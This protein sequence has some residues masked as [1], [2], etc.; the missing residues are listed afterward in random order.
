MKEK[1]TNDKWAHSALVTFMICV[2]IMVGAV[3]SLPGSE[4]FGRARSQT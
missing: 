3:G 2:A 1:Q 4:G